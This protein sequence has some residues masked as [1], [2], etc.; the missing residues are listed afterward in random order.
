MNKPTSEPL[1]RQPK[2]QQDSISRQKTN[3][4][5]SRSNN[6]VNGKQNQITNRPVQQQNQSK[7][8]SQIQ[9]PK[10][11]SQESSIGMTNSK[12]PIQEP[13]QQKME[14]GSSIGK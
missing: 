2:Q 8:I 11:L 14:I 7:S 5:N 4:T 10:P 12:P 13:N 6:V 3:Q 9:Q 1:N